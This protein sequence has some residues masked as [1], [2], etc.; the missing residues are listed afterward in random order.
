MWAV[1]HFY[2]L[3]HGEGTYHIRIVGKTNVQV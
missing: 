3:V 1:P 2:M